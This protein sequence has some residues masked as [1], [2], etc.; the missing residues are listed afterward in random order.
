MLIVDLVG[1]RLVLLALDAY[2]VVKIIA[3]SRMN[4]SILRCSLVWFGF[5]C[6]VMR[7][8][9]QFS[10]VVAFFFR[11]F[12]LLTFISRRDRKKSTSTF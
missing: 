6:V 10:F 7:E 1:L 11:I 9:A 12:S 8:S 3:R 5:T 4:D 2:V